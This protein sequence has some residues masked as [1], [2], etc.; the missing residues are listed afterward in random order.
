MNQI[1]WL[2][3]VT[4]NEKHLAAPSNP[5][6]LDETTM[7]LHDTS[8]DPFYLLKTVDSVATMSNSSFYPR[9]PWKFRENKISA[10]IKSA[11]PQVNWLGSELWH[12]RLLPFHLIS[13][14]FK[15]LLRQKNM[16]IFKAKFPIQSWE[17]NNVNCIAP[18]LT[19]TA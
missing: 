2:V 19:F 8:G 16:L 5:P 13:F 4:K 7:E 15:C 9:W 10:G 6:F 14:C 3:Q 12:W 11:V 18:W 17:A 1:C